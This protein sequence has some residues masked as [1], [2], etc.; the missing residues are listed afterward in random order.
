MIKCI[1]GN[2]KVWGTTFW[3][4]GKLMHFVKCSNC[5]RRIAFEKRKTSLLL[6]Q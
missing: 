3:T 5:N 4:K 6:E 1:C 2:D